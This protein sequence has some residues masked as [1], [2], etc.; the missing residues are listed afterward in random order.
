MAR[1]IY[2]YITLARA[3]QKLDGKGNIYIYY[4][5]QS[6]TETRWQGEY[7]YIYIYITLARAGQKL[8]G[9]GNIYIY[10]IS[11]SRT[12]TRWQ[13]EYIYILH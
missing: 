10:Y 3:G 8:D 13:G 2:I 6:R 7:I 4:I 12:E 1:G 9:K 11:Q 5:S